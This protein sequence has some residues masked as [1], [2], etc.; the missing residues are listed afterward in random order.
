V[1]GR[2]TLASP[3]PAMLRERFGLGEELAIRRR[4]N[5]AP[6]DDVVCVTT[7]K[8]GEPRGDILRWG[9]VPFWSKDPATGYKMI[10]ARAE[11]VAERPAFRDALPTRRCLIVADG[12]YEWQRRAGGPKQP[13]WITREDGAPFAFAGLWALWR[14]PGEEAEPLRTCTIITTQANSAVAELHDRMP[15]I[16]P[17]DAEQVW[18]DHATPRDAALSLLEPLPPDAVAMREVS[19]LV[20]DVKHDAP[21]CLDPPEPPPPTLF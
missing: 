7:T 2:Y 5:V 12:F 17:A 9:L 14:P 3:N 19:R 8:E 20:N 18:L 11:T 6:T 13:Y 15:V 16:L 10:N 1:C 21:D 4:F